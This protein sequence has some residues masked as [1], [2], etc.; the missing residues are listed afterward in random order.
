MDERP[1]DLRVVKTIDTIHET[2]G[3][4]ICE[5]DYSKI[6]VTELCARA[7]I[8]KKTFYRYYETL[9]YLLAEFR[10]RMMDDYLPRVQGLGFPGDLGAHIR[11]FFE[12]AVE[13]GPVFEHVTLARNYESTRNQMIDGVMG[14]FL[15]EDVTAGLAGSTAVDQ[16]AAEAAVMTAFQ[17]DATLTI[18][19]QWVAGGKVIPLERIIQIA[20]EL[21][22]RGIEGFQKIAG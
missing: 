15:D 8:N 21:E 1:N 22:L 19:R 2:F 10:Q 11:A 14:N 7:R 18:Y 17:M 6:T 3:A 13:K 9:D 16:H 20:T 5:M 4:M 12:F